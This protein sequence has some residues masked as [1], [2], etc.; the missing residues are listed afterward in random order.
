[1]KKYLILLGIALTYS[2]AFSQKETI[3]HIKADI[4]SLVIYLEGAEIHR[5]K[6]I[7]L[8]QGKNKIIFEGLSPK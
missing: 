1:M 4:E 3:Q 6:T 2:N 7:K 5:S 8:S